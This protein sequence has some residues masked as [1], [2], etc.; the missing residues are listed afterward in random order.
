MPGP[1][2]PPGALFIDPLVTAA[3]VTGVGGVVI[4]TI[5][6]VTIDGND[7]EAQSGLNWTQDGPPASP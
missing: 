6:G 2:V 3:V 4:V 1:Y 7:D 5:D